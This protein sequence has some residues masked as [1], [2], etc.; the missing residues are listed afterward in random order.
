MIIKNKEIT[1]ESVAELKES[2]L[3]A[4]ATNRAI[5][6]SVKQMTIHKL[7]NIVIDADAGVINIMSAYDSSYSWYRFSDYD[8]TDADLID[9]LDDKLELLLEI[10]HWLFI[11]VDVLDNN[12]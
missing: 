2:L 5:V 8:F 7:C 4:L 1:A 6:V 9:A 3:S 12:A 10:Y 11:D